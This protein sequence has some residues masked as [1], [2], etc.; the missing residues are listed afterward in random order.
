VRLC[1]SGRELVEAGYPEDVDIACAVNAS[2]AVPVLGPN[3]FIA[4]A[5]DR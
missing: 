5:V 2:E 3:G 4:N 1:T